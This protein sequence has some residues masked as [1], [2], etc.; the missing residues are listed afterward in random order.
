MCNKLTTRQAKKT[1]IYFCSTKCQDNNDFVG[2]EIPELQSEQL[3]LIEV[4]NGI[5]VVITC[6]INQN[7]V[8][9]RPCDMRNT[10]AYYKQLQLISALSQTATYLMKILPKPGDLVAVCIE[11]DIYLRAMVLKFIDREH[12][13]VAF[14]DTG[15]VSIQKMSNFRK[16][17][18][19]LRN[20]PIYVSKVKLKG[21]SNDYIS[22]KTLEYMT[23]YVHSG[24]QREVEIKFDTETDEVRLYDHN[25]C[26]NDDLIEL[27]NLSVA[28]DTDNNKDITY[29]YMPTKTELEL[30]IVDN[31][32]LIHGQISCI[33]KN[34]VFKLEQIHSKIQCYGKKL[35]DIKIYT[36]RIS[37]LCVVY[38]GG[39]WYRGICE[40]AVGDQHPTIC[41]YDF[42]F[43]SLVN[44]KN[45]APMPDCLLDTCYTH[46]CLIDGKNEKQI[47]ESNLNITILFYFLLGFE[48][49]NF[50][51]Q[52]MEAIRQKILPNST[53]KVD[54]LIHRNGAYVIHSDEIREII[55]KIESEIP[56]PFNGTIANLSFNM[57][58]IENAINESNEDEVD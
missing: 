51:K 29:S 5:N 9:V 47:F 24:P 18:P 14:L 34:S 25:E 56:K 48:P 27:V 54:K 31:S 52:Q 45:I 13:R 12:I 43:W 42:G 39:Y 33:L 57:S 50:T 4:M 1:S 15:A 30:I 36:P 16:L 49:E 37:E 23:Q 10:A 8:Y 19:E 58:Q 38:I 26:L 32:L 6:I 2:E 35:K 55:S 20:L 44:N 41:C 11:E 3:Q 17:L 46:V 21:V 40:E 7:T 22:L 28:E 53:I